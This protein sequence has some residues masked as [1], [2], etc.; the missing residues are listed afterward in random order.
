MGITEIAFLYN[1][2]S[3]AKC[4]IVYRIHTNLH[5]HTHTLAN[6]FFAIVAIYLRHQHKCI[7][8]HLLISQLAWC[9]VR[10]QNSLHSKEFTWTKYRYIHSKIVTFSLP[11]SGARRQLNDIR[12][13]TML[14][15][16]ALLSKRYS[17]N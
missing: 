7:H 12:T 2:L 3:M 1:L 11:K 9:D 4:Q 6:L 15:N 8:T 16:N 10:K 17:Q 13:A 14:T 5:T